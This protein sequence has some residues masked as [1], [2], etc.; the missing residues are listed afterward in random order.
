M[1]LIDPFDGNRNRREIIMARSARHKSQDSTFYHLLNRVAGS[2]KFFPFHRRA[3]A[4]KFLALF[5]FYLRL[6]FCRLASFQLMGN[7]YHSVVYFE[8]FRRLERRQLEQ[9]ARWRFGLR[10][11]L[12]TRHWSVSQW[13]QFNRDLFDVSKFMQHVNGEFSKWFNHRYG[14]R[15]HFWADR[16]KNPELLDRR[17]LQSTILYTELNAVRAG[18]VK[19]PEDYRMGSAYWRWAGKKSNLL[20]PLEQLFAGGCAEDAFTGYRRLL[21]HYGA[22]RAKGNQAVIDARLLQQEAERGFARPGLYRRRLRFFS[23]GVALGSHQQVSRLLASYRRRGL[24][25]RRKNPIPQLGG[26]LYSL[27]EQRSHAFAPG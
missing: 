2:P 10:W 20:M 24:Y 11:K 4:R 18:L 25:R 3:A 23:D 27:R 22:V 16:F 12:K 5:E 8:R 9:R 13:E 14:R 1:R 15:G 7:H 6:Y 21:Y 19:R 17:S 26:P